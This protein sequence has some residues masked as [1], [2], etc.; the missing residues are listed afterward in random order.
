MWFDCELISDNRR[1]VTF[2]DIKIYLQENK[3]NVIVGSSEK[4]Q[5]GHTQHKLY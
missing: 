1:L 2:K 5:D 4:A 3:Q